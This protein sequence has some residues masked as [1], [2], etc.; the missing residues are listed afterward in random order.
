MPLLRKLETLMYLPQQFDA[1]H[2][3]RERG[4]RRTLST[5]WTK[6]HQRN[7]T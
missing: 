3:A 2:S 4:K 5:D 7:D 1:L 6:L